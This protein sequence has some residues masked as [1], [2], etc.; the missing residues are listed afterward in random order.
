MNQDFRAMKVSEIIGKIHSIK[1]HK[2]EEITQD[3]T[4]HHMRISLCPST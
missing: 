2:I 1:Q 4:S 3:L